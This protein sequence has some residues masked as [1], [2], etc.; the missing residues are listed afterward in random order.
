MSVEPNYR[1]VEQKHPIK[2]GIFVK[3]KLIAMGAKQKGSPK[4]QEDL[5][6]TPAHKNYL[7]PAI[8]SE[9]LRVRIESGG[10]TFNYKCWQPIGAEIQ[11][12]CDEYETRVDDHKALLK[13]IEALGFKQIVTVKK[14]RETFLI[15]EFV[16]AFDSVDGL[17]EFI[18]V[19]SKSATEDVHEIHARIDRFL[20]DIEAIL[21]EQDRRGYPYQLLNR[22]R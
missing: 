15:N 3:Q 1:E 19:E 11:T 14:C 4:K 18:E 9:W 2:N 10:S 12:H 8:V 7:E 16:V 22:A 20:K 5:Y 21:G 13:L 6:F 17:G